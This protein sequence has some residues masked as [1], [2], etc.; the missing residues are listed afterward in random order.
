MEDM[1]STDYPFTT[2]GSMRNTWPATSAEDLQ[3]GIAQTSDNFPQNN[4]DDFMRWSPSQ[5][6]SPKPPTAQIPL[7][8]L[9]PGPNALYNRRANSLLRD[10]SLG[11]QSSAAPQR[12]VPAST[13]VPFTFGQASANA[14]AFSFPGP[15]PTPPVTADQ[16]PSFPVAPEWTSR[17]PMDPN[18][19]MLVSPMPPLSTPSLQHSPDSGPIRTSSSASAQ[20]SPEP[21]VPPNNKKRKSSA[22]E[23]ALDKA[24]QK[25]P[26]KKT[27]HNMIEK[28]YRTNLNDKIAAL[29]DSVPSL[30][31]MARSG[32]GGE[33]ED[34]PEDLEGLTPAHKLNKATV[35]SK[36]TEY[37]RHLEKRNKRLQDELTSLK[38]RVDAYDKMAMTG[39]P[40][41]FSPALSTP[42]G[43]R[44]QN[45]PF[46]RTPG[47][48]H[49]S[50][51]PP[52]GM[53]PVPQD[54]ASLRSAAMG[55]PH[56][57]SAQQPYGMYTSEGPPRPGQPGP[58]VVNARQGSGLGS[59]IM[60]GALSG[61]MILEGFREQEKSGE[62]PEGRGLF[63]LP[64][65]L[66]SRLG[67]YA[68]GLAGHSIFPILRVFLLLAAVL[69]LIL[70]LFDLKP[71]SKKKGIPII[72][73][74]PAPSL[75][76]P[77]EVR[78]KAWLTAIQTVWVP[79]HSF[80]LE[81]AALIMKTLKLSMRKLIGWQ[82]YSFLT[83]STQEQEASRVRA[84]E[85]A[86]DAQLTGGDEEISTSRLL[87]TLL[88]SG[89]LPNMPA[90]RMLK[91][92]HMRLMLWD[93]AKA[94]YRQ[95][96]FWLFDGLNTK[97]A[98]DNWVTAREE[99]RMIA[100]GHVQDN[101]VSEPLPD[102]LTALLEQH[103]RD[104]LN[105]AI[106]QRAYNLAWNK[107]T[108]KNAEADGSLDFVV[109]DLAISSPLDALASWYSSYVLGRA[110][111]CSM[112]PKADAK[113]TETDLNLALRTAPPGSR[114]YIKALVAK[115]ML[116]TSKPGEYIAKAYDALP[117]AIVAEDNGPLNVIR[118]GPVPND[119]QVAL[120]MAK[121][122]AL[123]STASSN[124]LS[125]E[126]RQRAVSA[127]NGSFPGDGLTLLSFVA[128][129]KCLEMFSGNAALLARSKPGIERLANALRVWIGRSK[130]AKTGL[131]TDL[132][133]NI[134]TKCLATSRELVGVRTVEEDNDD[135]S[136]AG[137]VSG[138]DEQQVTTPTPNDEPLAQVASP[139]IAI[140]D[141]GL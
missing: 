138:E 63:A 130:G 116:A 134:V 98:R 137:Y 88:A 107:P 10:A 5:T 60:V 30:R 46:D 131:P 109:E 53:I 81:A 73:L 115:A 54:I 1:I 70:P 25:Q 133:A 2:V 48:P 126:A 120:T 47:A 135:E 41:A 61:L 127:I 3:L 43:S 118:E 49:G 89:T 11:L 80:P 75:A 102:H 28:R 99:N 7:G 13:S 94:G 87:L 119:I 29:R 39:G 100:N 77:V 18:G 55:Q 91:A 136:D 67:S 112:N 27:A 68:G 69:Y 132:R 40:F 44:F 103:P 79:Q 32:P 56:Y 96:W 26:V 17:V 51:P 34:E 4:W 111:T 31:V 74:A 114:S 8:Q 35:L 97:M 90:R 57:A 82:G 45:D 106:V 36:A 14:P 12:S 19:T 139:N 15:I 128:S 22:S 37:I 122:I 93:M 95:L 125:A 117:S 86:L 124:P 59:K 62:E 83:G 113:A 141:V 140:G 72:R 123:G 66:G 16:Q 20:S 101:E 65:T 23:D 52:Q 108:S 38:A 6:Q 42:D 50:H 64:F 84:W 85:I 92:L 105:D 21:S 104:V 24:G 110:L 129:F 58:P 76:S 78:R 121:C 33:E 9:R 71:Q